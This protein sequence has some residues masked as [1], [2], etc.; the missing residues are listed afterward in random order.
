MKPYDLIAAFTFGLLSSAHCIGMCGGFA[1]LVGATPK[2]LFRV[3]A[4]QC[5][6]SA[7]R[8]T[9]YAFLGVLAGY[10]GLRFYAVGSTM[11]DLQRIFSIVAGG[12][13]LLVGAGMLGLLRLGLLA[14]LGL[15]KPLAPLLGCFLGGGSKRNLFL[16][17]LA[18]GFL[19]CGP[20]YAMLAVAVAYGELFG[21]G[22]IMVAFGAGTVPAMVL[23]GSGA[24]L[25]S[26]PMRHRI[27]RVAAC[28]VVATGVVTMVRGVRDPGEDP[29]CDDVVVSAFE[30]SPAA[31]APGRSGEGGP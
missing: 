20:V 27:Y 24:R 8:I 12:L 4:R 6:Y 31:S 17:G 28:C 30:N 22:V 3:V 7:G 18:N 14:R 25:V 16:G 23:I 26:A 9:T 2:S 5:T 15:E 29:C 10:V 1:A 11:V 13:M 19:P 21:S